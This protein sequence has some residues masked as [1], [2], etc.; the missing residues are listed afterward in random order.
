MRKYNKPYVVYTG[1]MKRCYSERYQK[2]KPSYV[3][4]KV[5]ESWLKPENF[6][7]WFS[8][9]YNPDIMANWQLDKDIL[10]KDNKVYSP[11][12]CCFVPKEINALFTKRQNRRGEYPIGVSKIKYGKKPYFSCL[13]K[14][15]K[16]VRL[17]YYETP[18][19][20][21]IAYK[22]AKELHIK[23]IADSFKHLIEDRVYKALYAYK[24]EITD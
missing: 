15:G 12:T 22:Q 21:F 23:E 6:Y 11:E 5:C 1:M 16:R 9:N 10:V 20:A 3:G 7:D 14:Y 24:V 18:Q 2:L 8:E 13:G 17:G 19:E 4:T